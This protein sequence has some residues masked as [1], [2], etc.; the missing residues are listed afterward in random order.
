MKNLNQL[1]DE[2]LNHYEDDEIIEILK[3]VYDAYLENATEGGWTGDLYHID[4]YNEI[5]PQKWMDMVQFEIRQCNEN[6]KPFLSFTFY[7]DENLVQVFHVD[8][9]I[10]FYILAKD[11]I[12]MKLF[13]DWD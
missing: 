9:T 5:D 10:T 11:W 4:F 12:P 2:M 8:E 13:N 7:K 6:K 3:Q 1:L